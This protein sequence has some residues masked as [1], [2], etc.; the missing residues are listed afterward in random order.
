MLILWRKILL[1]SFVA[2]FLV[3]ID[4][5]TAIVRILTPRQLRVDFGASS[6]QSENQGVW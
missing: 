5:V 4:R 2:K 1:E 6:Q 3:L